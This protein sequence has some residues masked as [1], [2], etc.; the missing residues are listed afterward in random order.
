MQTLLDVDGSIETAKRSGDVSVTDERKIDQVVSELDWDDIVVGALQETK[1]FESEVY[2]VGGSVV[3]TAGRDVPGGNEV[4]Q[5][6]EGVA[7]VLSVDAARAWKDGGSRWKAWSSRLVTATLQ[8]GRGSHDHL[9]ILSCYAPT[10]AASREDKNSFF[11]TLQDALLSIPSDKCFV[12][13]GDFNAR[14]GSRGADDEWWYERGP[15]GYGELNEAGKE[16]LSF[17]STNEATMCNSWFQKRDIQKQTWQHPKS[18]KWHC[19]D[20]VIMR[21]AHRRKCLDVSVMRGAEYNTDHRLM[22]V[23]VVIGKRKSFRRSSGVAGV[24]R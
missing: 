8:V 11:D 13:L 1:W 5:R 19:I 21:Q 24:R 23:K 20:Y 4:R 15:H 2:R 3:L 17:L 7:I 12:M 6:G 18:R 10:I 9:H 16:L 22:R 14:V